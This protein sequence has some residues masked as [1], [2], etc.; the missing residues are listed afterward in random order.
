MSKSQRLASFSGPST[1]NKF[2]RVSSNPPSPA[3]QK[4]TL[5]TTFHRKLRSFLLDF[6]NAIQ[7]WRDLILIDGVKAAKALIDTRTE[8][9]F[10]FYLRSSKKCA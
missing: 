10:D 3:S 4:G 8:L 5:E 1:P 9:E 7:T 2:N 6:R